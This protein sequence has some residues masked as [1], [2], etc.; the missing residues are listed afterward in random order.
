MEG[1][2][3]LYILWSTQ[4]KNYTEHKS[5]TAGH[6]KL[7][8]ECINDVI[9]AVLLILE[10]NAHFF[11][12]IKIL[13]VQ[14]WFKCNK[15]TKF[16]WILTWKSGLLIDLSIINIRFSIDQLTGSALNDQSQKWLLYMK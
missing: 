12:Q 13:I 10:A 1:I 8:P 7:S 14:A 9:S 2:C 15:Y 11:S 6:A 5:L 16:T 3:S 4:N